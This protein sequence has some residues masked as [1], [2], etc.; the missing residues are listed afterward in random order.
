MSRN[1]AAALAF[2]GLLG[3]AGCGTPEP[4]SSAKPTVARDSLLPDIGDLPAGAQIE[5]LDNTE[6]MV[7]SLKLD[8]PS[9]GLGDSSIRTFEPPECDEQNRYS[10]E[11]RI[12]LIEDGSATAALFD[13]ERAY[14]ILVSET[15][16]DIPR[17]A[18]AHTGSCSSYTLTSSSK[19]HTYRGTVRTERLDPPPTLR[20]EDAAILSEVTDPEIPADWASDEVLLGYAAVNGYT[21]MVLGY[22]G[23]EFEG[24]FAE[25]FTAAVQ[26]VRRLT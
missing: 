10:D 24:E 8:L 13:G 14:V 23:R 19:D 11:A 18:D 3:A 21:V 6:K 25:L 22:Q 16:M 4:T 20:S 5:H 1:C 7:L 2:I 12:S 9:D 17:V 15:K 26:K